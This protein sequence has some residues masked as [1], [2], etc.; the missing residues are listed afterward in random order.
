[1][2]RTIF[3]NFSGALADLPKGKRTPLNALQVL[4]K[5][6]RVSTF[7]R[8]EMPWLNMLLNDLLNQGLILQ[9]DQPYRWH[10]YELM[11]AGRQMLVG[12][13]TPNVRAK[14]GAVGDSA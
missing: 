3:C 10:R 7:D 12:H 2:G 11:T 4:E 14:P 1:M 13:E 6:P 8:S 9:I 5:H